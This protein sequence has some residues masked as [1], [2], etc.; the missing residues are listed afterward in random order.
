MQIESL[1]N[2]PGIEQDMANAGLRW[3]CILKPLLACGPQWA[4]E[5][6]IVLN[7]EAL[8]DAQVAVC[9]A[10]ARAACFPTN[11]PVAQIFIPTRQRSYD[12]LQSL[13]C[14]TVNVTGWQGHPCLISK[15]LG[16]MLSS[17]NCCAP[18]L[19]SC[20]LHALIKSDFA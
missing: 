20:F 2:I 13:A 16:C 14:A 12:I 9:S 17:Q 10:D 4:H 3:P 5:L 19:L 15:W 18:Y 8:A 7:S 6:V 1:I 11:R